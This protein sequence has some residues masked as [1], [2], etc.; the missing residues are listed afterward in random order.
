MQ[1]FSIA[2][3]GLKYKR[4]REQEERNHKCVWK[5]KTRKRRW[6]RPLGRTRWTRKLENYRGIL[7]RSSACWRKQHCLAWLLSMYAMVNA[8][9]YGVLYCN[10]LQWFCTYKTNQT[11]F[12]HMLSCWT[13]NAST[14]LLNCSSFYRSA[15]NILKNFTQKKFC[16][17]EHSHYRL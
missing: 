7:C 12:D 13:S 4:T 15:I 1:C 5:K 2:I 10:G 9:L 3:D 11:L 16:C 17:N 6:A 14:S 8:G